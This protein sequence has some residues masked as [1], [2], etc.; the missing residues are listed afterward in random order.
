MRPFFPTLGE[1]SLKVNQEIEHILSQNPKPSF[2]PPASTAAKLE[3]PEGTF[4][5][6]YDKLDSEVIIQS[7]RD[8]RVG[9]IAVF[10]G[11][12]PKFSQGALNRSA[13]FPMHSRRLFWVSDQV[14]TRLECQAHSTMAVKTMADVFLSAHTNAAQ[15]EYAAS[16]RPSVSLLLHCAVY[17]RLGVVPVGETSIVIA[18]S[19]PHQKVASIACEYLLE[20]VKL[21]VPILKKEV[22]ESGESGWRGNHPSSA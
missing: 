10:I 13:F 9:A 18:V 1:L 7:V 4:V 6:T 16:S 2:N 21:K 5:L 20:Q 8:D 11:A 15:S 17:H 14:I 3:I 22:Y 12:T 19:P